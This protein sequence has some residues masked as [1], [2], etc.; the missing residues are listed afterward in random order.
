MARGDPLPLGLRLVEEV[1]DSGD[2]P[3]HTLL[4]DGSENHLP[5]GLLDGIELC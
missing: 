5:G 4:L 3:M 1:A 2:E